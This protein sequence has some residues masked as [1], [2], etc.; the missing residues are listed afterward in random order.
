M[1]LDDTP[2]FGRA[3]AGLSS[4][5]RSRRGAAV[6]VWAL[7]IAA[8][9]N[10]LGNDFAYDDRPIIVENEGIHRLSDLPQALTEPYWPNEYGQELGLWRPVTTAVFGVLWAAV[11]ENAVPFH[12]LLVLL[13]GAVTALVLLVA[14]ELIPLRWALAGAAIFAVH[15]VHVEAVANL[16]GMAEVLSS[17]AF[18]LACLVLLRRGVA[19]GAAGLVA[20][21]GLYAFAFLT[22]ESAVTLPGV[23]LLLDA[24]RR[25]WRV[26][27]LGEYL[28]RRG[29]LYA[30]LAA[31]AVVVLW[32]RVQVLGSVASPFGPLG[33]TLIEHEVPRIWTVAGTWPHY[34]RLLFFPAELSADYSPAVVPILLGWGAQNVLGAVLVL[35]V[36]AGAWAAWRAGA[37]E[38]RSSDPVTPRAVTFGVLW[39]VIT[40]S[41]VA[42]VVFLS[43]VLL[44]ER[45]LYL[46]SVGF[47]IA[48]AWGAAML[49]RERPR[50][51]V[52]GIAAALALMSARTLTRNE[53][54]RDNFTVFDTLLAEHPESGRAQ[55]LL[56]DANFIVGNHPEAFQAYRAAISLLH[57][58]YPLLVEVGRRLLIAGR[59]EAAVAVLERAWKDEPERAIAPQVLAVIYQRQGRWEDAVRAARA[60]DRVYQGSDAVT[61]H[62]LAQSL[63]RLGR[64]RESA[65]ERR[66]T[67][68]APGGD[69][70]QQWYWLAGAEAAAGDTAAALAALDSARVRIPGSPWVRQIDSLALTLSPPQNAR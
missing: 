11:G 68:R 65:T 70:W 21:W 28:R 17:A 18:L 56:G 50:A 27:D 53:T 69:R 55:W 2:F 20:I 49:H 45:T 51:A 22:K 24:M 36:L 64:W 10:T 54:W 26:R 52:L 5:W 3:L 16:V 30:G 12:I 40:I 44:A 9:L 33:A 46:P 62:L 7:A 42:N 8:H 39:F 48:A 38:R 1:T 43:G 34:L 13:H 57:G 29:V 6:L 23:V 25:E 58:S 4:L 19:L 67:I 63:G 61:L 14:A 60:A 35:L 37:P 32:A 31:V 47:V 15:P 59:E 66:R 41:P